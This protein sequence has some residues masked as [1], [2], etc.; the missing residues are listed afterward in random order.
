MFLYSH[1]SFSLFLVVGDSF[2]VLIIKIVVQCRPEVAQLM[3]NDLLLL[4]KVAF[5]NRIHAVPVSWLSDL[6]FGLRYRS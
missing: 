1:T 6:V 4:K 2:L 3:E 5:I